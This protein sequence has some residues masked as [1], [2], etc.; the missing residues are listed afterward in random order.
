MYNVQVSLSDGVG[1]PVL[2]DLEISVVRISTVFTVSGEVFFLPC[3][4][5]R[6]ERADSD[7]SVQ[8]LYLG[9]TYTFTASSISGSHPFMIGESY[10]DMDSSL[11]SGGPL[12]GAGGNIN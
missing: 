6:W 7:F 5:Y 2:L 11:V 9:E 8:S 4:P 1:S 3:Y 10:G 12:S